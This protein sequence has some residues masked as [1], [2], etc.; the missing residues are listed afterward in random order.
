MEP[1]VSAAGL[2]VPEAVPA[3]ADAGRAEVQ[4]PGPHE[5]DARAGE[6]QQSVAASETDHRSGLPRGTA[7]EVCAEKEHANRRA[8]GDARARARVR[9]RPPAVR[10]P[11][12]GQDHQGQVVSAA[13]WRVC[14]CLGLGSLRCGP[15]RTSSPPSATQ[16]WRS[17]NAMS[18]TCPTL[19]PCPH[20]P[21]AEARGLWGAFR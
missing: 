8:R 13:P 21:T 2:P 9:G 7:P 14:L 18:R 16:H 19:R 11:V 3:D 6:A 10:Y 17:S 20:L 1:S 4:L 12:T 15:T 5:R